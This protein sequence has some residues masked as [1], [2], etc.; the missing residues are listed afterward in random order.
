V[1][2]SGGTGAVLGATASE[3][4]QANTSH[5]F[6]STPVGQNASQGQGK[7]KYCGLREEALLAFQRCFQTAF[8]LLL[9]AVDSDATIG[10]LRTA[11]GAG[12]C[13]DKDLIGELVHRHAM[14]IRAGSDI[15]QPL[16]ASRI[17]YSQ[18]WAAG[19]VA[20]RG[21]V[22][23]VAGVIPDFVGTA[24]LIDLDLAG[25]AGG[26]GRASAVKNDQ[27]WW[28]L[29]AIMASAADEEIVARS[30]GD[31][32]RH[33]VKGWDNVDDY[34]TGRISDSWINFVDAP[35]GDARLSGKSGNCA[36]QVLH[37]KSAMEGVETHG[38][39]PGNCN[40]TTLARPKRHDVGIVGDECSR[41]LVNDR[42]VMTGN[43]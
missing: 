18:H 9:P 24:G 21:V 12:L 30:L 40:L 7:A 16:A 17:D 43:G 1:R 36:I 25:E 2:E 42:G 32:S 28:E 22:A 19:H 31:T 38:T 20:P 8:V 13:G 15:Y 11:E 37:I 26:T 4:R 6:H 33:A 23:V 3:P 39:G 34:R 10:A 14:G 27:Q 35:D 41:V 29:D 5:N